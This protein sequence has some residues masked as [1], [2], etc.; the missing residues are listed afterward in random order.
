MKPASPT[1]RWRGP[2]S[3]RNSAR[4]GR[5]M[6]PGPRAESRSRRRPI[7]VRIRPCSC[8][9]RAVPKRSPSGKHGFVPTYFCN[10]QSALPLADVFRKSAAQHGRSFGLGENQCVVRWIQIG[11]S[12]ED[13]LRRVPGHDPG[14]L[15]KIFSPG[16]GGEGGTDEQ[17]CSLVD[18][19][20]VLFLSGGGVR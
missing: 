3:R 9:G 2:A 10:L 6:K 16:G 4:P 18:F 1:G 12:K 13:A 17:L 20:L 8:R 14:T 15:E 5:W 7:P 11:K 19:G